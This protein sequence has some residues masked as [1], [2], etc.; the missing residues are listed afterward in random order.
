[1][2]PHRSE[3]VAHLKAGYPEQVINIIGSG[4]F[5]LPSPPACRFIGVNDPTVH[6]IVFQ[7]KNFDAMKITTRM[8]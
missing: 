1:L 3:A 5:Q 2:S 4:F 7:F 6:S 8:I